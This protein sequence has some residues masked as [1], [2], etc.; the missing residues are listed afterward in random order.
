MHS[1]RFTFPEEAEFSAFVFRNPLINFLVVPELL[2]DIALHKIQANTARF[3]TLRGVYA[4]YV[5]WVEPPPPFPE[6]P[7]LSMPP[8]SSFAPTLSENGTTYPVEL[9]SGNWPLDLWFP[10]EFATHY[11][12]N[13]TIG[14]PGW[15]RFVG[16]G[17]GL[18]GGS[19]G[20]WTRLEPPARRFQVHAVHNSS[21]QV[22]LVEGLYIHWFEEKK[23]GGTVLSSNCSLCLQT[24]IT[25]HSSFCS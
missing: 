21:V 15:R 1:P 3:S 16:R 12:I 10:D 11:N 13:W 23:N 5:P 25:H 24:I 4:V 18:E 8:T 22:E 6:F 20:V 14:D 2:A 17:G 9:I 7:L 19:Q